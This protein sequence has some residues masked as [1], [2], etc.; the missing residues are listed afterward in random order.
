MP[1][2]PPKRSDERRRRN[3]DGIETVRLNLDEVISGEVVIPAAPMRT[4]DVDEET[5]E[6]YPLEVPEPVW[7]PTAHEWYTA[8]TRSG[9]AIF[10]EPS[11]WAT[12]YML[13]EQIHLALQPR[14]TQIGVD[15]EGKPVFKYMRM[16]MV[17]AQLTAFLK[18]SAALMAT[19]GE[20]RK[21]R[22]ELDRKKHQDAQIAGDGNVSSIAQKRE[23]VFK[24]KARG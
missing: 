22:I 11:D 8:L 9:Q 20:R 24:R 4:H 2:P 7:H 14:P 12:A 15:G 18:G 1:G 5:G 19:E 13:A 16:P 6:E 17:G 3:K 21:L 23:D 10:F